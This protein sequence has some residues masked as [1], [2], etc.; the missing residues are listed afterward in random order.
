MTKIKKY[1]IIFSIVFLIF[2][3]LFICFSCIPVFISDKYAIVLYFPLWLC[4]LLLFFLCVIFITFGI[5]AIKTHKKVGIA[6][7]AITVALFIMCICIA[8]SQKSGVTITQES[9]TIT[10][11]IIV[12]IL[13]LYYSLSLF[14]F[15]HKNYGIALLVL[16]FVI[17]FLCL[18]LY[19]RNSFFI[20]NEY[21]LYQ[22][23]NGINLLF[24]GKTG[25]F[26]SNLS[27]IYQQKSLFIYEVINELPNNNVTLNV[28]WIDKN[29]EYFNGGFLLHYENFIEQINYLN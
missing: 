29:I 21:L 1:E 23:D 15:E 16:S 12:Q 17:G 20:E 13:C 3:L 25:L 7:L 22:T 27:T 6:E 8:P 10:F 19:L 9:V 14:C 26:N 4:L 2:T 28:S 18:Y 24:K 5:L 11:L